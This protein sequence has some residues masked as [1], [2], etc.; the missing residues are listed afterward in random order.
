MIKHKDEPL[1]GPE[2][3]R[4]VG[5]TPSTWRAYVSRGQA[6]QRDGRFGW[7]RSTLDKWMT[8]RRGKD[9]RGK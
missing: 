6:P 1:T 2:S 8:T 3:A 5:V 9:W 7:W 4:Y